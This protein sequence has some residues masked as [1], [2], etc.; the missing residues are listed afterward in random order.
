MK[1]KEEI[2]SLLN[3]LKNGEIKANTKEYSSAYYHKTKKKNAKRRKYLY[4]T[5]HKDKKR[6]YAQANKERK[7][8]YLKEWR[9]KNPNYMT[10]YRKINKDKCAYYSMKRLSKK[11]K[12]T[13][14][15]LTETYLNEIQSFFTNS[16]KLTELHKIKYVVD[17][18][19][20]L[21]GKNVS[22]L[23]VPWNLQI[24]TQQENSAK[25]NLFDGTYDNSS[26]KLQ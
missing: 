13:P 22:G 21:Q 7:S 26:W 9:K 4:Q 16:K 2:D 24:I 6:R 20:P 17:H 1:T 5:R 14:Q 25:N 11:L 23:H 3:R 10:K 12:R 8:L 19:I 15:W 18:I